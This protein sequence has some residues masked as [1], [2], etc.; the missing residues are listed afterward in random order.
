MGGCGLCSNQGR[1][2]HFW[3]TGRKRS[4]MVPVVKDVMGIIF[5]GSRKA[6]D[7]FLEVSASPVIFPLMS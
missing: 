7:G 3:K 5:P 1:D 6:L 4:G 2:V